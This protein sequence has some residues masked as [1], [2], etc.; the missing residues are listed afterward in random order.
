M[1]ILAKGNGC[2]GKAEPTGTD[3]SRGLRET[4]K[5]GV[6]SYSH[7]DKPQGILTSSLF[8][9]VSQSHFGSQ[10]PV[11]SQFLCQD[12]VLASCAFSTVP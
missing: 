6:F 7:A 3:P 2:S 9:L 12:G 5:G 10:W 11:F 4:H 8:S 1:S